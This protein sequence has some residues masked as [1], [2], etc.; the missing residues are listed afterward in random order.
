[1]FLFTIERERENVSRG[2]ADRGGRE[3]TAQRPR[4]GLNS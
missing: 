1:M 3:L 4:W 2:E